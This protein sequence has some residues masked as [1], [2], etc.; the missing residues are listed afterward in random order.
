MTLIYFCGGAF[1]QCKKNT[2]SEGYCIA[3]DIIGITQPTKLAAQA[4]G[5]WLFLKI[6]FIVIP[7]FLM[8]QI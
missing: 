3:I 7:L 5:N 4:D 8:V 1:K 2:S 6:L